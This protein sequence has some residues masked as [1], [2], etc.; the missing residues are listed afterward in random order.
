MQTNVRLLIYGASLPLST[1]TTQ[2]I[3]LNFT[4]VYNT[5]PNPRASDLL[6]LEYGM[7]DKSVEFQKTTQTAMKG[8]LITFDNEDVPKISEFITK[9]KIIRDKELD[10]VNYIIKYH[11]KF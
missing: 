5:I 7:E 8:N 4:L 9:S 1:L 3:T 6:P 2:P 11:F 10:E